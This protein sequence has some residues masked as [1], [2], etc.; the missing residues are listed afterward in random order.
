MIIS[1]IVFEIISG[2]ILSVVCFAVAWPLAMIL[3]PANAASLSVYISV[4]SLSI[5][6]GAMLAAASGIFVGFE[7]MKLNSFTQILQAVVK[8][9]L[10]P[11]LIIIGFGVLGAVYATLA[12]YFCRRHYCWYHSLFFLFRPLR[13]CKVGK[14]DVK[15]TLKPMLKFGLPLTFAN[16]VIGVLPQVF[17]FTMAVYAGRGRHDG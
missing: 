13:K 11:L 7:R 4:M 15:K 2:A 1:G 10:G 14:C 5:F 17:A 16:I 6:A 3:S 12:S 9:A 8:T